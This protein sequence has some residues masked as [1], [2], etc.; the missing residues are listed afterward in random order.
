MA[1]VENAATSLLHLLGLRISWA[2]S[3]EPSSF[4]TIL[5]HGNG[6]DRVMIASICFGV[7]VA[8]FSTSR[9]QDSQCRTR[10]SP[11]IASQL[12]LQGST[13]CNSAL[14]R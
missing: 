7:I 8:V 14:G 12:S 10:E 13:I 5:M 2:V 11:L 3:K 1:T 6:P 4:R 9:P